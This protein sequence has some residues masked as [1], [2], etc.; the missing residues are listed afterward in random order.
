MFCR[1][2]GRQEVGVPPQEVDTGGDPGRGGVWPGGAGEGPGPDRQ[3]LH[4]GGRQDAQVPLLGLRA[5]GNPSQ[6][7]D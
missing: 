4:Q 7:P 5:P 1:G 2:A 3:R 6:C